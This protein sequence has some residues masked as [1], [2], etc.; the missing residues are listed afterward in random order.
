MLT[1]VGTLPGHYTLKRINFFTGFCGKGLICRL[2]FLMWV[3]GGGIWADLFLDTY[4][5]ATVVCVDIS[6][7]MLRKNRLRPGKHL[8]VANA[9]ELPFREHTFDLINLDA[10]MHHLVDSRGYLETIFGIVW[11]LRSLRALLKPGGKVL[12]REIYHESTGRPDWIGYL[13]FNL[14]TLPLS[15]PLASLVALCIRSQGSGICFLTRSQW[16]AVASQ[17]GYRIEGWEEL[18]E[19]V[20]FI[21]K[22][23]GF[24]ESGNLFMLLSPDEPF[25]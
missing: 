9:F 1:G 20:P 15:W 6:L 16:K 21:R 19:R 13:L 10:L 17:A 12:I 24:R 25:R 11:F 18:D 3:R 4:P 22:F 14:S 5:S 2:L 7:A 23:A 8:M